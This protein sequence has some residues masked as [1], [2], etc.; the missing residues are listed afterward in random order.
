MVHMIFTKWPVKQNRSSVFLRGEDLDLVTQFKYLGITLDTNLTFKK[1]IKKLSNTVRF[2]LQNFKQIFIAWFCRISNAVLWYG[3]LLVSSHWNPLNNCI[4]KPSRYFPENHI[5]HTTV[6]LL[7][8]TVSWVLKILKLKLKYS[9]LIYKILTGLSLPLLE[10]F[11]RW[12]DNTLST[13]S[14]SR[15]DCEVQLRWSYIGQNSLTVKGSACWN[16]LPTLIRDSSSFPAFKKQF[17]EWLLTHQICTHKWNVDQ[18]SYSS[19][20]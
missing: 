17:K 8:G 20:L 9:C 15:R 2:S 6:Q 1:N 3:R 16:S 18:L 7:Q 12:R 13:R 19:P 4:K 5:L 10:D 14:A 11:F